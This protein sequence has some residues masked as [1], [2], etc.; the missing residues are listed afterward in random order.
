M[1]NAKP[2]PKISQRLLTH[3]QELHEDANLHACEND[4]I[5]SAQGIEELFTSLYSVAMDI[6]TGKLEKADMEEY[7]KPSE[8]TPIYSG[9]GHARLRTFEFINLLTKP[10]L[11]E[12]KSILNDFMKNREETNAA[13][14]IARN[15]IPEQYKQFISFQKSQISQDSQE[16]QRANKEIQF[17]TLSSSII[18]EESKTMSY[19]EH[20]LAEFIDNPYTDECGIPYY[21]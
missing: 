11:V 20:I 3:F 4:L 12:I 21:L 6:Q 15:A 2:K 17:A 19:R 8:Y 7:N 16:S 10:E 1:T 18:D 9:V 14:H 5:D 13:Y